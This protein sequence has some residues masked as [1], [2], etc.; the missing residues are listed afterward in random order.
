MLTRIVE[1]EVLSS[2]TSG[3]ISWPADRAELCC[4][5][6]RKRFLVSRVLDFH[7]GK[8]TF[9]FPCASLSSLMRSKQ[10]ATL[11]FAAVNS[12]FSALKL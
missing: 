9:C 5:D 2:P 4:L 7:P 8:F 11:A 1:G 12:S 10:V 6:D 3:W